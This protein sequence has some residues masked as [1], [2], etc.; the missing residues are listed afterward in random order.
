MGAADG[1][2][3]KAVNVSLSRACAWNESDAAEPQ[4]SPISR[5]RRNFFTLWATRLLRN[6]C[7]ACHWLIK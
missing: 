6:F 5:K 2:S 1:R 7:A 4:P 3:C